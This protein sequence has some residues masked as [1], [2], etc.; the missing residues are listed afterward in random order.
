[1]RAVKE[2]FNSIVFQERDIALLRGLFESRVMT[3]GHIATLFFDGK[4]EAAKKRLQKLKAAG[5]IGERKRKAYEPSVLFLPR[6]AFVLLHE[7]G[8]LAEYPA[9]DLPALER[10]ARVSSVTI[11][12]ELNVMDVK[13]AFHSAIKETKQ[14]TIE[15]FSTWPMLYEFEAFRNGRG[16]EEVTVRP[17]GFVRIHEKEKDGGVSEHTFYL[18]VDRSSETQETLV[19]RA[20]CYFDYYK[21]GSFAVRNGATRSDYKHFPF[22]VLM[23]FKTAERRNNTAERLLQNNPPIL[24]QVC[25]STIKEVMTN[26]LGATWFCPIDYRKA[27]ERTPFDLTRQ[28]EQLGYQ[29]QTARE[30]FIER[31]VQKLKILA[32]DAKP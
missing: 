1:M 27:V 16:G 10:R 7:K 18:E 17:D 15:E 21:S 20:G 24:T 5:L 4:K 9:F 12:H 25:L 3:A 13:T 8:V 14:F 2:Q 19:N 30:L 26:P 28:R 31:K 29:R 32:D 6:K 11:S 22:R 23:V